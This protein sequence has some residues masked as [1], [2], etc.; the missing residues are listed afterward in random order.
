VAGLTAVAIAGPSGAQASAQS[1]SARAA[2]G[3]DEDDPKLAGH[4][5]GRVI[6]PDGRPI[7]GARLFVVATE[8]V[9]TSSG[10]VRAWSDAL[11]SFEFDAPDMTFAEIDGLPS[12]RQGL[13]IATADH[14]EPDWVVTW[15]Q[16][17]TTIRSHFDPV[18]G[19]E[20]TL[21]LARGDVPIHGRLLDQEGRPLAGARV[22]LSALQ[23]PWKR[24]LDAHLKKFGASKHQVWMFDYERSLYHPNVLP[25]V[26]TET[27]TDAD[28]RF[29][30]SG[31]GRDRLADL[32]VTAASIVDADLTVM[33]R[34][35][36]DV[37]IDQDPDGFP[38]R[39]ILGAGFTIRLKPGRTIRG[40]VRDRETRAP[41]ADAWVAAPNATDVLRGIPGPFRS[42]A[43]GRYTI[44]GIDP[45]IQNLEVTAVP[46]PGQ[47]YLMAKAEVGERSGA[48]IDCPRGIRFRLKL[49]NEAGMPVEAKVEYWAVMPNPHLERLISGINYDG[50]LPLSRAAMTSKGVYEGFVIP[51]P[52]AVTVTTP[53]E[54]GFGSAHVDP[55]A[56]FAPGKTDWTNQ[57]QISTYGTH[58]TL[59]I[60]Y[61]GAWRDQHDFTS[62]VL[63]NPQTGSKP[64]ELA[65]TI[66]R[67]RPRQVT[68][69]DPAGQPVVGART[70]GLT[71][72]PWD[73]E[74]PLRAA[75]IPITKLHPTRSRRITFFE[76][77]RK[78]IG[79]L[80]ARGDGDSPYTV[81]LQPQATVIGRIVDENGDPLPPRGARP[82][83]N[84][85]ATAL[86]TDRKF[87]IA[88]HDDP[89]VGTISDCAS[90]G[91][92][93]FRIERLVPGLRYRCDIYRDAGWY[94]GVAFENLVL[95][96]GEVRDLGDI[97][98][99]TPV[100]IHGK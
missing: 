60:G 61:G 17:R 27:I 30:L 72:F 98:S 62:I 33:T 78:L 91:E 92:G 52:G 46:P 10:P 31:L 69:L 28:G 45:A 85:S 11:G 89:S 7:A 56:F 82:G 54:A 90:D 40:I 94:A 95:K 39:A 37:V 24:D 1:Q 14:L 51:G 75:T 34:D 49:V 86:G 29:R 44:S 68:I 6:G 88:T 83:A 55:K 48:M 12:R 25:G 84:D 87:E 47:P 5:A 50:T 32:T 80:L 71:A 100:D 18:K 66:L 74:P 23:V 26:G 3:I 58:D 93:R 96:P 73:R 2:A 42:D 67:D 99:K 79:F 38:R 22:R 21:R 41:I 64:L 16:T 19:A 8:P 36:P 15:G 65:A 81:N 13:L 35:A 4:F 20:I 97:R 59:I 77:D 63:V 53:S 57:E 43:N 76:E 70:V 9:P